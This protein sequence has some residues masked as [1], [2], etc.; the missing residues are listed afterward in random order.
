MSC[1]R[2]PLFLKPAS[3]EARER[4]N[5]DS[6]HSRARDL[7]LETINQER[8]AENVTA[9]ATS[10]A[11]R[12]KDSERPR[13]TV[14]GATRRMR[15]AIASETNCIDQVQCKNDPALSPSSR[16]HAGTSAA[17]SSVRPLMAA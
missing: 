9:G 11:Y 4:A 2:C 3:R 1:S 14:S 7:L 10:G 8:V 17:M 13:M 16:A 12:T 5:V 15:M 6:D